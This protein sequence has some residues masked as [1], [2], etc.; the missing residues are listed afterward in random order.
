MTA[1]VGDVGP[2]GSGIVDAFRWAFGALTYLLPVVLLLAAR[3][4]CGTVPAP[5][6]GGG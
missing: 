5:R 2:V 1:Y 6:R 4:C 3:G